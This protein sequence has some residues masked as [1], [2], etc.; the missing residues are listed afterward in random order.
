MSMFGIGLCPQLQIYCRCSCN[1]TRTSF[2]DVNAFLSGVEWS[3]IQ[4]VNSL[5]YLSLRE[6]DVS[7]RSI[8]A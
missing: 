5:R 6:L 8:S 1:R 3:Y 2:Q 7:S 4:Y